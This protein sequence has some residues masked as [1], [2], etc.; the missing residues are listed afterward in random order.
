MQWIFFRYIFIS[1]RRRIPVTFAACL[2]HFFHYNLLIRVCAGVLVHTMYFSYFSYFSLPLFFAAHFQFTLT[3]THRWRVLI[4]IFPELNL[5][6]SLHCYF[7]LAFCHTHINLFACR[8]QITYEL[9]IFFFTSVD[10]RC[11]CRRRSGEN[12]IN[13]KWKIKIALL[14]DWW[15]AELSESIDF[16]FL[17]FFSSPTKKSGTNFNFLL[18]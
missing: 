17:S 15:C 1:F 16:I 18:F 5:F 14:L 12:T 8:R 3:R 9:R 6:F 10:F 4:M 13:E 7:L 11:A 2:T